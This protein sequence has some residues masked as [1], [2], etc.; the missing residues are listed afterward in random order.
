MGSRKGTNM[1]TKSRRAGCVVTGLVVGV[2]L[3]LMMVV[4]LVATAAFTGKNL[5][6]MGPFVGLY[7]FK[8]QQGSSL[9]PAT[10]GNGN[11]TTT[12]AAGSCE[13]TYTARRGRN[14]TIII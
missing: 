13:Y 14:R 2:T 7:I 1:R 11:P 9:P 10:I 4:G 12:L 3:L 6:V 5:Y 8:A